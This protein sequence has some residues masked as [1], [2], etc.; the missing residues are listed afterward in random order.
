MKTLEAELENAQTRILELD[1][2]R[3]D[4]KARKDKIAGER[5][6]AKGRM[7]ELQGELA[8]LRADVEERERSHAGVLA[9]NAREHG[10]L[11]AKQ[12]VL[13]SELQELKDQLMQEQSALRQRSLEAEEANTALKALRADQ[14]ASAA[15]LEELRETVATTEARLRDREA[16]LGSQVASKT[17]KLNSLEVTLRGQ[18]RELAEM[19]RILADKE[20]EFDRAKDDAQQEL[21]RERDAREKAEAQ[22][23]DLAGRLE[24]SRRDVAEAKR[25]YEAKAVELERAEENAERDLTQERKS[26]TEAIRRE[27]VARDAAEAR[28]SDLDSR[29]GTQF[30]ELS[31]VMRFLSESEQALTNARVQSEAELTEIRGQALELESRRAEVEACLNEERS[32]ASEREAQLLGQIDALRRSTSWRLTQPLRSVVGWFRGDPR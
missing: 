26:S 18:Y 4:E 30:R 15:E 24:D 12:E 27:R 19:T 29:L 22:I 6:Q 9:D 23:S 14:A 10:M 5:D 21:Q 31:E 25:A 11:L 17:E 16:L 3:N 7:I 8:T 2:A 13:T 32:R 1:T 28:A 20:T